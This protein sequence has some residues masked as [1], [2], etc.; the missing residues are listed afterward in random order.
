[1]NNIFGVG[2]DIVDIS[3]IKKLFNKNKKI[4]KRLFSAAEINYC[5]SKKK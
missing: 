1:M 4:K 2:T 5:E 3:R